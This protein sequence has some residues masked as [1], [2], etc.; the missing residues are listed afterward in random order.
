M[1]ESMDESK[2][3]SQILSLLLKTLVLE[4]LNIFYLQR[5]TRQWL[6][7]SYRMECLNPVL[8][9]EVERVSL[10]RII[11]PTQYD[12]IQ[13]NISPCSIPQNYFHF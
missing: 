6:R 13:Q 1:D 10:K 7:L 3:N 9:T 11:Y 8:G 2:N 5:P 4:L 12:S